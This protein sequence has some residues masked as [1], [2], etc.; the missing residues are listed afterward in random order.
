M[1]KKHLPLLMVM[2]V[3]LFGAVL[4]ACDDDDNNKSTWERYA[5]WRNKNTA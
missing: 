3:M 1:N 4:S 2:A 5:D